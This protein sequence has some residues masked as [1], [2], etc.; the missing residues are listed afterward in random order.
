MKDLGVVFFHDA[1]SKEPAPVTVKGWLLGQPGDQR[2][3][4]RLTNRTSSLIQM[5]YIADRYV[6][7]TTDG[8]LVALPKEEFLSYPS[9]L[10]PA[11]ERDV[12]LHLPTDLSANTISRLTMSLDAGNTTV[13]LAPL[14]TPAAAAKSLSSAGR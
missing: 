1:P 2:L 6:I 11:D 8:R 3:R 14:G 5:S 4:L 13:A 9:A 12:I 7:E 10:F